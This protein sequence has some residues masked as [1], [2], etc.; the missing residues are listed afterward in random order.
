MDFWLKRAPGA[1]G[2]PQ[3]LSETVLWDRN[4]QKHIGAMRW[5]EGTAERAGG[6]GEQRGGDLTKHRAQSSVGR[7]RGSL[8]MLHCPQSP[9]ESGTPPD[10]RLKTESL[11]EDERMISEVWRGPLYSL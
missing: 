6:A 9:Q 4:R 7:A 8:Y 10:K 3:I 5:G 1:H 11:S 2:L